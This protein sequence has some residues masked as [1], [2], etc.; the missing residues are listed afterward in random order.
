MKALHKLTPREFRAGLTKRSDGGVEHKALNLIVMSPDFILYKKNPIKPFLRERFLQLQIGQSRLCYN[1]FLGLVYGS[2]YETDEVLDTPIA[3]LAGYQ[4]NPTAPVSE[5]IQITSILVDVYHSASGEVYHRLTRKEAGNILQ[6]TQG[7]IYGLLHPRNNGE[8][9]YGKYVIRPASK[10]PFLP[11][12]DELYDV[13]NTCVVFLAH[14]DLKGQLWLCNTYQEIT[15]VLN[16]HPEQ[17][18]TE[19]P[20]L[21]EDVI[22][23]FYRGYGQTRKLF[24][25]HTRQVD[26]VGGICVTCDFV[27]GV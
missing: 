10:K 17:T 25:W 22:Q 16:N 2:L 19:G 1:L 12:M 5:R 13:K 9:K 21:E 3:D 27:Q 18:L 26:D 14:P 20:V 15:Q 23:F 24:G 7:K 8:V 6:T 4:A 11:D